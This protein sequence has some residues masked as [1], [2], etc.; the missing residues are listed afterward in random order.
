M[1]FWILTAAL[2]ALIAL[3]FGLALLRRHPEEETSTASYDVQVYRDQLSDLEKDRARGVISPEE[4]ERTR[5]E[6]SRRM[7]EADRQERAGK[8]LGRRAGEA[9]R[10]ATLAA[11]G[12]VVVLLAAAFAGYAV[13]G[14]RGYGDMP[15]RQRLAEADTSYESRPSQEEAEKQAAA[16][17]GPAPAVD[18][19]FAELMEKLRQAVA[20]RPADLEGLTLLARNE[21]A[22]GNFRAGY[23]AQKR[24]IAAKG[25]A[26]TGE[27]YAQLGEDMVVAAGG[28]VTRDAE[29]A[30]AT[31]LDKEPKNGLALYYIGLMMGQNGRPDRAFLLWDGLLRNT[32]ADAPWNAPI[33]ANI[34]EL[35]WLAGEQNYTPP[36]ARGPSAADMA[37]AAQMTPEERMQMIRGMVEQLNDRL[38]S[39]GGP[40]EDWAKL[41]SSLRMLGDTGRADAIATEARAKFVSDKEALAKID[42]AT[43][44]PVGAAMGPMGGGAPAGAP[45][46]GAM[47]GPSTEDVQNAATMSPEERQQMIRGMVDGLVGRLTTEGGSAQEWARAVSSLAM[48]GDTGRAKEIYGKAQEALAGD[49]AALAMVQQAAEAAKVA[50]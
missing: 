34:E 21:M 45:M 43:Q 24:L 27:D 4:A 20:A 11:A 40:V 18:P 28:L 23:E 5:L 9:P 44:A 26:A 46:A 50:P 29:A 42:A 38:A 12:L 2:V 47:P 35:A 32:P 13:L 30:F 10:G 7:L 49:A 39:E 31:A 48:L 25:A 6:I 17:R 3:L 36:G 19:K 22:M 33:R 37:N 14:A 16:S 1:L 41:V 15:I 8:D